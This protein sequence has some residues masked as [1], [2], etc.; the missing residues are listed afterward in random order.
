MVGGFF[1]E[2]LARAERAAHERGVD[3]LVEGRGEKREASAFAMTDDAERAL[4]FA[5]IR[6]KVV[7]RRLDL[8][9]FISG[10]GASQK[11]GGALDPFA[12]AELVLVQSAIDETDHG[13][14]AAASCECVRGGGA[15]I[16]VSGVGKENDVG[17]WFAGLEEKSIEINL[18]ESSPSDSIGN[19]FLRARHGWKQSIAR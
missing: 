7:D 13:D 11:K 4:R 15:K 6:E 14:A 12:M 10:D 17:L 2:F 8:Q 3:A 18:A 16:G 1:P 9:D 5:L 19:V